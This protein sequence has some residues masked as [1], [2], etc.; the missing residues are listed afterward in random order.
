MKREIHYLLTHPITRVISSNNFVFT[1]LTHHDT[2]RLQASKLL[3][4][5]SSSSVSGLNE[6]KRSLTISGFVTG[7]N[8]LILPEISS[9]F[10]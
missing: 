2:N 5:F 1:S 7:G 9:F 4:T 10:I 8:L 3:Y 6:N